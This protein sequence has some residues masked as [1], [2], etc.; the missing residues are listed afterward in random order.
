[1]FCLEIHLNASCDLQYANGFTWYANL[2]WTNFIPFIHP[3]IINQSTDKLLKELAIAYSVQHRKTHPPHHVQEWHKKPAKKSAGFH[4]N[5]WGHVPTFKS[6][7]SR[8]CKDNTRCFVRNKNYIFLFKIQHYDDLQLE[9]ECNLNQHCWKK[10]K[11]KSLRHCKYI[12]NPYQCWLL[13][14]IATASACTTSTF[15]PGYYI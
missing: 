7:F 6:A 14:S 13:P 3:T 4:L 12:Y 5:F 10:N 15:P 8:T 9:R 1:M 11:A 2:I